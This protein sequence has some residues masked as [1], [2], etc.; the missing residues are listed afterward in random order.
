[1]TLERPPPSPP[2]PL[3]RAYAW[4]GALVLLVAWVL[5]FER[6]AIVTCPL[7]LGAG[8]PCPT[9]GMTRAFA[10]T[11]HLELP[12]AL[13]VSPLGALLAVA[14]AA[15]VVWVALRTTVIRRGVV[16]GLTPRD[17]RVLRIAAP[18]A[19]AANWLYLLLSGA[20]TR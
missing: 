5:P 9:C 2:S 10:R 4:V 7:R 16:L 6:V 13:E 3:A 12:R 15:F 19:V 8:V 20:A 18:L 1:M 17:K 11:M 14:T